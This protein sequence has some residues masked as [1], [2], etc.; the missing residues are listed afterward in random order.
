MI[1]PCEQLTKKRTLVDGIKSL[2]GTLIVYNYNDEKY[3][4]ECYFYFK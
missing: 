2:S 1:C 3:I 4:N